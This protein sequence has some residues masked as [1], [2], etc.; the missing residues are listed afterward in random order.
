MEDILSTLLV[1]VASRCIY[2]PLDGS[3]SF[4]FWKSQ[5]EME[6]LL[7]LYQLNDV[8]EAY[9]EVPTKRI[10]GEANPEFFKWQRHNWLDQVLD[11]VA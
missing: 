7:D 2:H 4:L 6:D 10:N 9:C 3:D 8:V 5:M 1:S 11:W